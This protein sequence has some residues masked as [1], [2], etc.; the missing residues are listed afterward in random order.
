MLVVIVA[1]FAYSYGWPTAIVVGAAFLLLMAVLIA[2]VPPASV[3]SRPQRL[4][5]RRAAYVLSDGTAVIEA[6]VTGRDQNGS[7]PQR[8]HS[9]STRRGDAPAIHVPVSGSFSVLRAWGARIAG[10]WVGSLARR[11]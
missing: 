9:A 11:A 3:P 2:Q 6:H 10:L 7:G 8:T 1:S 5:G 4:H